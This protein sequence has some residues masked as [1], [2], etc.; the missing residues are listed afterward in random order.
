MSKIIETRI[1]QKHDFEARWNETNGFIP[2]EGEIIVYDAET[3]GEG[4]VFANAYMQGSST[5]FTESRTDPIPYA[6]I[7]IGDGVTD[8]KDLEFSSSG[9]GGSGDGFD[10]TQEF[11]F[12]CGDSEN[13][14]EDPFNTAEY[15]VACGDAD[16]VNEVVGSYEKD[17]LQAHID[18][19]TNPHGV[20]AKQSGAVSITGDT[21]KGILVAQN[22]TNYTVKQVRNII[23]VPEGSDLPNG[24]NGDICFT[25][26]V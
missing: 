24:S 17:A 23:I 13:L 3:N 8:V 25:Y 18:D 6:R 14:T 22:N 7:K 4:T 19:K 1:S 16:D 10:P 26:V 21:M 2:R 20:T 15:I 12:Y 5:N 9:E 11:V